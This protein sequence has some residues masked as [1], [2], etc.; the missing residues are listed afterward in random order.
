MEKVSYE[1]VND[2]VTSDHMPILGELIVGFDDPDAIGTVTGKDSA[3]INSKV[4]GIDGK[5]ISESAD[6]ITTLPGGI[7]IFNG[8]KMKK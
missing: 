1:V 8:K 2:K 6:S 3:T 4:Y 7:Y 5:Y